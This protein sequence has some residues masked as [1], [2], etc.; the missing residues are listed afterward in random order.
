M[1]LIDPNEPEELRGANQLAEP[2]N[3]L[4]LELGGTVTGEHGIGVGKK[5]Y[6]HAEHGA[7]YTL[8]ATIKRAIDPNNIM[9]PGKL[10]SL[11]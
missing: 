3:Q 1:I 6:M 2:I 10:V 9:N 4:A 5:H 8:M 7:G 11:D